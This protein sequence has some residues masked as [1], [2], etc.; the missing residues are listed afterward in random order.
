MHQREGAFAAHSAITTDEDSKSHANSSHSSG[1]DTDKL[2]SAETPDL[3]R[4]NTL[5][6]LVKDVT[7]AINEASSSKP[8]PDPTQNGHALAR[9][10]SMASS[11][12]S[13]AKIDNDETPKRRIAMDDRTNKPLL[14]THRSALDLRREGSRSTYKGAR[15]ND[16]SGSDYSDDD[17]ENITVSRVPED[18]HYHVRSPGMHGKTSSM[19]DSGHGVSPGGSLKG[20]HSPHK[21]LDFATAIRRFSALPRT[22]SRL[23]VSHASQHSG[24]HSHDHQISPSFPYTPVSAGGPP[25]RVHY[26]PKIRS[27]WPEAMRFNDVLAKKTAVERCAGYARKINELANHDPGLGDWVVN[28]KE[29]CKSTSHFILAISH[30]SAFSDSSRHQTQVSFSSY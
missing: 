17:F 13:E 14:T 18:P 28:T 19:S 27:R 26:A 1:K 4:K 16:D 7:A 8:L 3:K 30:V 15:T 11:S 6:D 12:T 25:R 5:D 9:E 24:S 2:P 29:N 23:S 21:M 10:P 22:P 20:S